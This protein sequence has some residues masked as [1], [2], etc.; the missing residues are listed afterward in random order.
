MKKTKKQH[1]VPRCYLENFA[2]PGTYQINVYDKQCMSSRINS[3]NDI[4]SENY[5]YDIKFSNVLKEDLIKE[6]N[7][8][9]VSID[10]LDNEQYIEHFLAETIEGDLSKLL[11]TIINKVKS[12]TPWY[13][14]NCFF[15]SEEQ[16]INLSV[17][18]AVQYI[19]TKSVREGML[20]SSDCMQQVLEDMN[21]SQELK[22]S[23]KITKEDLK[24]IHGKMIFDTDNL[25]D[26]VKSFSSLVWIL[27]INKTSKHFYTTDNPIGTKA[28]ISH[29]FLSMGGLNSPGVEVFFPISPEIILIMYDGEYHKEIKTKDRT[30]WIISEE[31]NVD[32]YNSLLVMRSH[33]CIFSDKGDF[34]L[35][36]EMVRKKPMLFEN[37][38]HTELQ[39]GGNT[40]RPQSNNQKPKFNN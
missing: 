23:M 33:R 15:I 36:E 25:F 11:S 29:P 3:I 12:V 5:F 30:Y 38:N 18:L 19:R 37:N 1:Y 21:A 35:I 10:D 34:S 26:M 17:C 27:G 6:L 24:L 39:W 16:K 32:Y 14:Q 20:E 9:G 31:D 28:H 40:Y 13:I 4:A 7:G 8:I 22:D 2:V